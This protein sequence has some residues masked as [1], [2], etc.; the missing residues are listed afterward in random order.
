[1]LQHS[2][3]HPG[4][5]WRLVPNS[6]QLSNGA[7][8]NTPYTIILVK[9]HWLDEPEYPRPPWIGWWEKTLQT[10][11]ESQKLKLMQM[12]SSFLR[13]IEQTVMKVGWNYG[14]RC[15]LFSDQLSFQSNI[16]LTASFSILAFA[17]KFK[18][19]FVGVRECKNSN[20]SDHLGKPV[21]SEMDEFPENFRRKLATSKLR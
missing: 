2:L 4:T 19:F 13:D 20:H 3:G 14:L 1:M 11:E 10:L 6:S 7:E 9:Q 5:G 16:W 18:E 8:N 12:L 17:P 21:V 15:K